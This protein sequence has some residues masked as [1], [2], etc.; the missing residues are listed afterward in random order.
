M[1][2]YR[3]LCT[4]AWESLAFTVVW[5]MASL[6]GCQLTPEKLLLSLDSEEESYRNYDFLSKHLV[7]FETRQKKDAAFEERRD[8]PQTQLSHVLVR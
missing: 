5:G 7:I 4:F 6:V 3:C 1:V 8:H 2:R